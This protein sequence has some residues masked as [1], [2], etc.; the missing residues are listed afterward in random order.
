M[1]FGMNPNMT[2]AYIR[3]PK[4]QTRC[5]LTGLTRAQFYEL[6][7]G[8]QPRVRSISLRKQQTE[9]GVR[10]VAYASL[11]RYLDSFDDGE[12]EEKTFLP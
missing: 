8:P 10:L 5:P 1:S 9:R 3:I 4:P 2:P 11:R 6:I 12:V 7:S